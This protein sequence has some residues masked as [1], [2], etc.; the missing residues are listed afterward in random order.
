MQISFA[1][2]AHYILLSLLIRSRLHLRQTAAALWPRA[3]HRDAE[4][5]DEDAKEG[6]LSTA[7]DLRAGAEQVAAADRDAGA[8]DA[9]RARNVLTDVNV[10]LIINS[11]A[12]SFT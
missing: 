4:A 6:S 8:E 11:V 2:K 5:K 7:T 9:D 12:F 3:A 10:R 1:Y